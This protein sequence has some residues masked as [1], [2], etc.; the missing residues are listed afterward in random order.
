MVVVVVV[1]T[2]VVIVV[3]IVVSGSIFHYSSSLSFPCS[4]MAV[5]SVHWP[6]LI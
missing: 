2:V 6:A 4:A 1:V 3:V 5:L